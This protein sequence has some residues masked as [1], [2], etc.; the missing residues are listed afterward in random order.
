LVIFHGL[1]EDYPKGNTYA[2]TPDAERKPVSLNITMKRA[3]GKVLG[4]NPRDAQRDGA[5]RVGFSKSLS[6]HER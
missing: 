3:N 2:S 4:L 1:R 6:F 5:H